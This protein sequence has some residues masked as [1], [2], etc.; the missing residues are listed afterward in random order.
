M[1]LGDGQACG[2]L[3]FMLFEFAPNKRDVSIGQRGDNTDYYADADQEKFIGCH[4]RASFS[5]NYFQK[6]GVESRASMKC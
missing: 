5:R 2:V 6:P 1:Q 4:N 3:M